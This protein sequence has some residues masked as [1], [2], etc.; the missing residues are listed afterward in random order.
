MGNLPATRP[1]ADDGGGLD[2]SSPNSYSSTNSKGPDN[3][4]AK[5]SGGD[6]AARCCQRE[7]RW[8]GLAPVCFNGSPGALVVQENITVPDEAQL[9]RA[10]HVDGVGRKLSGCYQL[11]DVVPSARHEGKPIFKK[12]G[13]PPRF[14]FYVASRQSWIIGSDPTQ[15]V[16]RVKGVGVEIDQVSE[17]QRFH[18][19]A[20][21]LD[22]HI[23]AIPCE[24]R[25][26]ASSD[27]FGSQ[28]SSGQEEEKESGVFVEAHAALSP[29]LHT[30]DGRRQQVVP[31]LPH[32]G[33][34]ASGLS[35]RTCQ[36]PESVELLSVQMEIKALLI[37]QE[38]LIDDIAVHQAPPNGDGPPL[39]RLALASSSITAPAP[40][41]MALRNRESGDEDE[42]DLLPVV[43]VKSMRKTFSE[44]TKTFSMRSSVTRVSKLSFSSR[45]AAYDS[46]S[47][48]REMGGASQSAAQAQVRRQRS[49][50]FPAVVES[51]GVKWA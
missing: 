24:A 7:L 12:T 26:S 48:D 3:E 40:C 17:W 41:R 5:A 4:G 20:W 39:G 34:A 10:W 50:G 23:T 18:G 9:Y 16:G 31:N 2:P 19:G 45:G 43:P 51:P 11:S 37:E 36:S 42:D 46:E 21:C 44:V 1:D 30:E 35:F 29:P 33:S 15:N 25:R 6:F 27:C 38:A 13:E 32:D 22:H 49:K 8:E 47:S 14:L 28:W